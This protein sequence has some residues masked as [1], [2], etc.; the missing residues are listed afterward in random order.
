MLLV[1]VRAR[2]ERGKAND[3]VCRLIAKALAVPTRNVDIATGATG[4]R[5]LVVIE[6]LDY[7]EVLRRFDFPPR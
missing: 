3:S 1:R 6:G 7:D 2:P 5:K 4:R